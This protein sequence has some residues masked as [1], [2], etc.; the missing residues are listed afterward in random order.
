[1]LKV[2]EDIIVFLAGSILIV[3]ILIILMCL[4]CALAGIV[5]GM[6]HRIKRKLKG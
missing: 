4:I 6:Y 1:M 2:L 5:V 3:L